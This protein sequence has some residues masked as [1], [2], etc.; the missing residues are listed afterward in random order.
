MKNRG[1]EKDHSLYTC[2]PYQASNWI[3]GMFYNP[4]DLRLPCCSARQPLGGSLDQ[5]FK[6]V[7]YIEGCFCEKINI[8]SLSHGLNIFKLDVLVKFPSAYPL[9]WDITCGR[10]L[11]IYWM[12]LVH[13]GPV[14]VLPFMSVRVTTLPLF[15]TPLAETYRHSCDQNWPVHFYGQS[16]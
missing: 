10:Y 1:C 15:M 16:R 3:W 9:G 13:T 11:R 12:T 6:F 14:C 4:R 7:L 8:C 5:Q 2:V